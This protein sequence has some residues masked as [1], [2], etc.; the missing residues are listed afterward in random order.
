[1]KADGLYV[2]MF[3]VHGLLRYENME[4]GRDADTGG[5][6]KYVVEL[7][8]VLSRH[9]NVAQ[10][11]LFTRLISDRRVSSDYSRPVEIISDKFRIIRIQCGGKLYMRKE[12]LWPYLDEYIDKTIKFIKKDRRYPDIVHGHYPD[13][14]YVGVRLSEYFGTPFIYTGHSMGRA[15][16]E[17]LLTEGM[18]KADISRKYNIEH[19]IMIEE[20]SIKNAD[21][22][23]ASTSQEVEEQYGMYRNRDL[24]EYI[25]LPPGINPDVFYPHYRD[26]MPGNSK[27]D[28]CVLAYGSLTEELGRFFK[29]PD[30]P[31]ILALCR[32]DKRKNIAGLIDAYGSDKEL[33]A[34]ANLAIFAGIRKNITDM[35]DNEKDVLTEMLLLMDKYD[36]YGKMAIPKKHDFTYEVPELY[37]ITGENRGVFVNVA[38]T[39]PFGL[40]LIEA[41]ACGVPIVATHDGGPKDIVRNCNNGIL[42]NPTDTKAVS[43]AL[44]QILVDPDKWKNFSVNGIRGVHEHYIWDAHVKK[45]ME[46]IRKFAA[47]DR[48]AVFKH[49]GP[50]PVGDRL[51]RL[52][53]FLITDIDDTLLGDDEAL[54]RLMEIM[55]A[56]RDH[57]G[58]GVATGRT[59]ES[60]MEVF[61]KYGLPE[62]DLIISSVGAEM[63]YRSQSF[64]DTG[65]QTYISKWWNREKITTV[66]QQFD[67]L[68]YQE[69][70]TQRP[71]KVSYYMSP[72]KDRLSLL[73]NILTRNRCHCNIIYSSDQFLDILPCRASKGKAVRYLAYKWE[74]PLENIMVCGDSGNDNKMLQG[75]SP[76]VVV[77]NY[78]PELEHLRGRRKI[79]F[80]E[81]KYAAGIIDGLRHYRLIEKLQKH[82]KG[83]SS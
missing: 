66:L 59:V 81:E 53:G 24:A 76:G 48:E 42:V 30:K 27:T 62:P 5:Q 4:L 74:I 35:E 12:L 37:R 67:F 41:A 15:K 39:E 31:L 43:S 38:L 79:F 57:I 82:E 22:I 70:E 50:N 46:R 36:L 32:A 1:M 26:M 28:E 20:E 16:K 6:I 13:A 18:K 17:R 55:T 75:S 8:E 77:G 56:N 64:P 44:K 45:Y 25:V 78:K 7:A 11:D 83:D 14:G 60:T 65:W 73:H 23:V 68:E 40:T 34:I 19:R 33:Q 49:S 80:S 2:Q 3:S 54:A 21:L 71:F 58:F 47:A 52:Q 29:H 61:E 72:E 63:Y 51:I 69:E 9:E 10:V